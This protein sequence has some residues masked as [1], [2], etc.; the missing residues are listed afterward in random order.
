MKA[1]AGIVLRMDPL[2]NICFSVHMY[3]NYQSHV[4]IEEYFNSYTQAA[5]VIGEFGSSTE[6]GNMDEIS[7]LEIAYN[8]KIGYLAWS[9]FGNNE[10]A[11]HIDLVEDWCKGR[12]TSWG[13]TIFLSQNGTQ[14][15]DHHACRL[16]YPQSHLY[17]DWSV[18]K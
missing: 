4:V 9:W 6:F 16:S 13:E 17:G 3:S 1:A 10:A 15:F 7:M 12:L 14:A 5:I 2:L 11:K 8:L 18:F